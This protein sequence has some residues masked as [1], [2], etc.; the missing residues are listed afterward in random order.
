M[1]GRGMKGGVRQTSTFE[2][3]LERTGE[4][5]RGVDGFA[6]PVRKHQRV[7]F[8]REPFGSLTLPVV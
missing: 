6:R 5:V 2:Q 8:D 3:E 1:A 7:A 4:Q